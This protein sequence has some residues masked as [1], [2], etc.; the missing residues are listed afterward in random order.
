MKTDLQ[1]SFGEPGAPVAV[2][3]FSD[4]QC[5]FCKEEAKMIRQNVASAFPTQVRVYFKDF[6]LE[7]IHPWAKPAAVAGRCVFR[8]KPAAFWD[9]HDWIFAHQDEIIARKLEGEGRRMGKDEMTRADPIRGLHREQSYG[10][11]VDKSQAEGRALGDKLNANALRQWPQ[12]CRKPAM[13]AAKA[14]HRS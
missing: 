12:A 10:T 13:A 4:F 11:E 14:D 7:P 3:M 2:V 6:P 1:P 9:Y 8:Q 5:S